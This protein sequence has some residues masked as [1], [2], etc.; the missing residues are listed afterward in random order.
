M[1]KYLNHKM[2]GHPLGIKKCNIIA[3]NNEELKNDTWFLNVTY[4]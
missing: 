1:T 4:F 3:I 2:L